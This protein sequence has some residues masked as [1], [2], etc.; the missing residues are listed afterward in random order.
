MV[1]LQNRPF[2]AA[3]LKTFIIAQSWQTEIDCMMEL[4]L[5]RACGRP[6]AVKSC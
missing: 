4:I 6:F 1:N 3:T 2:T 5:D